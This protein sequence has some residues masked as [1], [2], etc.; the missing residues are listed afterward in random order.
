MAKAALDPVH[1][2][3]I[4]VENIERA[5]RWY[6]ERFRCHVSYQDESWAFLEFANI[7]LALVLPHQHPAHIAF[8]RGDAQAFGPLTPHRDGT[9]SVYVTDSEGNSVEILK[10]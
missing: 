7:R 5:I 3:A 8:E 6:T 10:E 1:H 4:E 9:S 2:V